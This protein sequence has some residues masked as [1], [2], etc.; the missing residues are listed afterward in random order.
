MTRLAATRVIERNRAVT[1]EFHPGFRNSVAAYTVGLSHPTV[2]RDRNLY[3]H[4][5]RIVDSACDEFNTCGQMTNICS[6][7]L[8]HIKIA[9]A[10]IKSGIGA[11]LPNDSPDPG[12]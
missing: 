2:N 11:P 5:P 12:P 4:G 7:D 3:G 9:A 8:G 6:P 1:E 10:K